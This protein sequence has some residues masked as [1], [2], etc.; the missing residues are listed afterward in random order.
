[1]VFSCQTSSTG[2]ENIQISAGLKGT[3]VDTTGRPLKNVKIFCLY[4]QRYIFQDINSKQS[5]KKMNTNK[6]F[7]FKLEQNFPNPF[8][9]STFIRFAL[10]DSADIDFKVINKLN[11]KIGYQFSETLGGGYYQ[12]YLDKIVEKYQLKNGPW[13]YTLTAKISDT[14]MYADTLEL[15]VISDK[16]TPNSITNKYGIFYFDYREI[17]AGDSL[18]FKNIWDCSNTIHLGNTVNLLFEKE[19]Y[20]PDVISVTMYPDIILDH[21]VVLIKKDSK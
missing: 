4:H 11:N 13:R 17:F 5:L 19:G 15:F 16:G 8:S 3:V 18:V 1:M 10:P 21:D 12:K 6:S 9:N 20:K 14:L 7:D 2:I